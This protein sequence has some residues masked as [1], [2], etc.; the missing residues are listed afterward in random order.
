MGLAQL[1]AA[2]KLLAGPNG[3]AAEGHNQDGFIVEIHS[4]VPKCRNGIAHEVVIEAPV[5]PHIAYDDTGEAV[6]LQHGCR[7]TDNGPVELQELRV[8]LV[9]QIFRLVA[10]N[11]QVCIG[12]AGEE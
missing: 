9:G 12:W 4:G 11:L 10:V 5:V 3:E 8:I 1:P 2:G 6:R 7:L